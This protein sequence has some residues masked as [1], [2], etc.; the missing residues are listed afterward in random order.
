[1]IIWLEILV[2]EELLEICVNGMLV[3]VIM[4]MLGLDF[5]LV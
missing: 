5:E 2:V 4:C 1:M 3:I